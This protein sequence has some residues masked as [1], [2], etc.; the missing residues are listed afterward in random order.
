ME[1]KQFC[2]SIAKIFK[3]TESANIFCLN[4]IPT[5]R[6]AEENNTFPNAKDDLSN[7]MTDDIK[8][9]L[10]H[11]F[12]KNVVSIGKKLVPGVSET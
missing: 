12:D 10:H 2:H 3:E 8:L 6:V 5:Y 9:Y 7:K 4:D 11:I 1:Y